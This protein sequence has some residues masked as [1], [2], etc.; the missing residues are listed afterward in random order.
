MNKPK[1]DSS[2]VAHP[3]LVR[4]AR[5]LFRARRMDTAEIAR[6]FSLPEH[7]VANALRRN[8]EA[9]DKRA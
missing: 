3:N 8:G 7:V 1:P 9:R 2:L 5:Y 4:I 6:A